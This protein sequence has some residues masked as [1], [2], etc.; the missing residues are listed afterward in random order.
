MAKPT[1]KN[2]GNIN[3][4]NIDEV[5]NFTSA[6]K[7]K[8][9]FRFFRYSQGYASEDDYGNQQGKKGG[10]PDIKISGIQLQTLAKCLID[11][12]GYDLSDV[13]FDG[14]LADD[15]Q[16]PN[17]IYKNIS[18][19]SKTVGEIQSGRGKLAESVNLK[20]QIIKRYGGSKYAK[21]TNTELSSTKIELEDATPEQI[22]VIGPVTYNFII[23]QAIYKWFSN[24]YLNNQSSFLNKSLSRLDSGWSTQEIPSDLGY[25]IYVSSKG[26][27]NLQ[28][29]P[30]IGVL[31]DD[32]NNISDQSA[33][34]KAKNYIDSLLFRD[35]TSLVEQKIY[36]IVRS[37]SDKPSNPTRICVYADLAEVLYA[38]QTKPN[39]YIIDMIKAGVSYLYKYKKE[40]YQSNNS[41][42][43][44]IRN[45]IPIPSDKFLPIQEKI[46]NEAFRFKEP[47]PLQ[48]DAEFFSIASAQVQDYKEQ[49]DINTQDVLSSHFNNTTEIADRVESERTIKKNILLRDYP[50]SPVN[51]PV[52]FF[53]DQNYNLLASSFTKN[54]VSATQ[55]PVPEDKNV[56]ITSQNNSNLTIPTITETSDLLANLAAEEESIKCIKLNDKTVLFIT[57]FFIKQ[58][59]RDYD[60]I[61]AAVESGLITQADKNKIPKADEIFV[62]DDFSKVK[63]DYL[64][65]YDKNTLLEKAVDE[66]VTLQFV[67]LKTSNNWTNNFESLAGVS[68]S[69]VNLDTFIKFHYPEITH[70]P[71]E[72]KKKPDPPPT[73]PTGT[74]TKEK[75]VEK[76]VKVERLKVPSGIVVVPNDIDLSTNLQIK[77]LLSED[78][79]ASFIEILNK[80]PN[81][82]SALALVYKALRLL[83]IEYLINLAQNAALAELEKLAKG[84]GDQEVKA[85]ILNSIDQIKQCVPP[86]IPSAKPLNSGEESLADIAKRLFFFGL[87]NVPKIPYLFTA[88]FLQTL[89]KKIAEII[90][91]IILEIVIQLVN[92]LIAEIKKYLCAP[93]NLTAE[94]SSKKLVSPTAT[95]KLNPPEVGESSGDALSELTEK[96][97]YDELFSS[98]TN[99]SKNQIYSIARDVYKV[100][101]TNN[102]FDTYFSGLSS[103]LDTQQ[104]IDTLSNNIEDSLFAI[105][106]NYSQQFSN[107]DQVI[108]NRK[109]T[110]SFFAL[111]ARYADLTPCYEQLLLDKRSGSYCFDDTNPSENFSG[112]E[113]LDKA[114]DLL[115]EITDLCDIVNNTSLNEKLKD[116]SYLDQQAKD[117]IS[118]GATATIS[119][120]FD[121]Y[122][123]L[124]KS[125]L[126]SFETIDLINDYVTSH[127]G[128]VFTKLEN[129]NYQTTPN[130]SLVKQLVELQNNKLTLTNLGK[131]YSK[132]SLSVGTLDSSDLT[133]RL[134]IPSPNSLTGYA[135][136]NTQTIAI[137]LK[138]FSKQIQF[139]DTINSENN[140]VLS[141]E[142]TNF[143]ITSAGLFS[144]KKD[145]STFDKILFDESRFLQNIPQDKA[146]QIKNYY[147]TYNNLLN[148]SDKNVN[149]KIE[150][151]KKYYEI[152][153]QLEARLEQQLVS[154]G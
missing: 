79:F 106:K 145:K 84:S 32:F 111:F 152:E 108:F 133:C 146:K 124:K 100:S 40:F 36:K 81:A 48:K 125:F 17:A 74:E 69:D 97:S 101:I 96:C 29:Y 71:S 120:A 57:E 122:K 37:K 135:V 110:S 109:T 43:Q 138:D 73:E 121:N 115:N 76:I 92:K 78:C 30:T 134:Q 41:T 126:D 149:K 11:F 9:N 93:L 56:C 24:T 7:A 141:N 65:C 20:I 59:S 42:I 70:N 67:K 142:K 10:K 103:I 136:I 116:L 107:F 18:P 54:P 83:D 2:S 64:Y 53:Y 5:R 44:S 15:S 4:I 89:K 99:I 143:D 26:N 39:L 1:L 91:Q 144:L 117:A 114:N 63:V 153:K 75:P 72:E 139:A 62:T 28:P 47:D 46:D 102:E 80:S 34:E 51:E 3:Y 128:K 12:F 35:T 150:N 50:S 87:L 112:Q 33:I 131:Y 27:P 13:S 127:D 25:Y 151:L 38:P 98:N 77:D 58:F 60:K 95:R 105:I 118:A 55:N 68:S 19:I 21:K 23:R 137:E 66:K 6:D 88:D 104:I 61:K 130:D 94:T 147:Y 140:N 52:Q 49:Y 86:P 82:D 90:L 8:N 132:S 148:N 45:S 123:T 16:I 113:I 154:L 22:G 129:V 31:F 14:S 119:R 85:S